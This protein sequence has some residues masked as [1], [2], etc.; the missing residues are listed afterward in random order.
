MTRARNI[1]EP[2]FDANGAVSGAAMSPE[3]FDWLLSCVLA[4]MLAPMCCELYAQTAALSGIAVGPKVADPYLGL[5]RRYC[6]GTGI[7]A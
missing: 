7:C 1:E 5:R 2:R 6:S 3:R 4:A